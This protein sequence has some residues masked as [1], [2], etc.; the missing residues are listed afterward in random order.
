VRNAAIVPSDT[1]SYEH[2]YEGNRVRIARLCSLLLADGRLAEDVCQ[3]VFLKLHVAMDGSVQAV[4]WDRWL[5]RVAVN[6]CKDVRRSAWWR[7]VRSRRG[8]FDEAAFA[9]ASE[10]PEHSARNRQIRSRVQEALGQLPN[11]QRQVFVL[12]HIEGWS[13][14]EVATA[15][16]MS[17][18]TVKRHLFRAVA[19]LRAA[20]GD[21]R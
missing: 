2:L 17:T 1:A 11:R 12:R 19:R 14:Q 16:S 21:M 10:E 7:R 5:T 8:D 18:G 3:E 13:T 4:D 15:L 9:A 20:L 6:A